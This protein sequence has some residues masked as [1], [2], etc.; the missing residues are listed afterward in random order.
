M[1]TEQHAITVLNPGK[2][3]EKLPGRGKWAKIEGAK[4]K[5]SERETREKKD[6]LR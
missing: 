6:D 2:T 5:R 1:Q 3:L 4:T